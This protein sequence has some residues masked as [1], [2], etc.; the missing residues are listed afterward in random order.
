MGRVLPLWRVVQKKKGDEEEKNGHCGTVEVEYEGE[1]RSGGFPL[2]KEE[3]G[4]GHCGT[5]CCSEY[6]GGGGSG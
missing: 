1:G 6:E 3:E 5:H 2:W 4:N